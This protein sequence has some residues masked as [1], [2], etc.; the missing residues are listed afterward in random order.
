MEFSS[1][2]FYDLIYTNAI[3]KTEKTTCIYCHKILKVFLEKRENKNKLII[4]PEL[5]EIFKN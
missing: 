3:K 5:L 4:I 2:Y 1:K